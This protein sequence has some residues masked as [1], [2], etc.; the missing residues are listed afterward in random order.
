M[1]ADNDGQDTLPNGFQNAG[2]PTYSI[3]PEALES[4]FILYRVTGHEEYREAARTNFQSIQK[5]SETKYGHAAISN[6]TV[7]ETPEQRDSIEVSPCITPFDQTV[8]TQLVEFL[9]DQDAQI[10]LF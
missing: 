2:D 10:P 8:L 5:A 4:V 3:R 7:T 9:D 6:V 1:A